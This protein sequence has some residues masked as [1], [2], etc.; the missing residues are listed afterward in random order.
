LLVRIPLVGPFF[1]EGVSVMTATRLDRFKP[2]LVMTSPTCLCYGWIL[3]EEKVKLGAI[4]AEFTVVNVYHPYVP[5][6]AVGQIETLRRAS[7]MKLGNPS[8]EIIDALLYTVRRPD[9]LVYLPWDDEGPAE[10]RE[11]ASRFGFGI[12]DGGAASQP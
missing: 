1:F 8:R 11:R 3:S 4:P 5:L 9:A 6:F 7:V 2:C 10:F 12:G